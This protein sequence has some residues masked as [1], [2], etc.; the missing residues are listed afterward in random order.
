[1]SSA[2]KHPWA[3]IGNDSL[4]SPMS[5]FIPLWQLIENSM[6]YMSFLRLKGRFNISSFAAC[7]GFCFV[8]NGAPRPRMMEGDAEIM[9]AGDFIH[10]G[11]DDVSYSRHTTGNTVGQGKSDMAKTKSVLQVL[12]TDH[13]IHSFLCLNNLR[14]GNWNPGCTCHGI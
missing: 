14:S 9:Q 5:T 7:L 2:S 8:S 11:N 12:R 13:F 10:P 4:L 3:H 1:M 6:R